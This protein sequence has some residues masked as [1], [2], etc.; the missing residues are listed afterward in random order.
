M[1]LEQRQP[2][3]LHGPAH[4]RCHPAAIDLLADEIDGM[5]Q[6][7]EMPGMVG[8]GVVGAAD[9]ADAAKHDRDPSALRLVHMP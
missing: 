9:V 8:D 1:T 3:D 7:P 5:A 4:I 6:P 2:A